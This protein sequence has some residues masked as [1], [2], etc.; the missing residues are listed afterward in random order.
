M[1][2]KPL[3]KMAGSS[4]H[5]NRVVKTELGSVAGAGGSTTNQ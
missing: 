2:K 1:K 3:K 5:N 4:A